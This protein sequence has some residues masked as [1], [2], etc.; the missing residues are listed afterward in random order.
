MSI[1]WAKRDP[2]YLLKKMRA[3]TGYLMSFIS[4]LYN[5]LSLED[6]VI[7]GS[8]NA[9]IVVTRVGCSSAMPN[10]QELE[11]FINQNQKE[12]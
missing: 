7:R 3:N 2:K 12:L 9:A 10:N 11:K 8:A 5:G 6:A 1:K 4:S